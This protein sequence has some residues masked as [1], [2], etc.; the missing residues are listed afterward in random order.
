MLMG[1]G[2]GE[3]EKQ[4]HRIRSFYVLNEVAMNPI[5]T[6]LFCEQFSALH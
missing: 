4:L 6:L 5:C 3:R 1:G 2:R